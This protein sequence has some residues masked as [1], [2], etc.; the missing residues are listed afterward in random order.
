L[1]E[2]G[3]EEETKIKGCGG[4]EEAGE[5]V[6]FLKNPQKKHTQIYIHTFLV[7]W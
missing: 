1:D 2:R 7:A 3:K 5:N 4:N 6:P